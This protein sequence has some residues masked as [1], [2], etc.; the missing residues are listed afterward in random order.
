M[1]DTILKCSVCPAGCTLIDHQADTVIT[2][3]TVI[4]QHPCHRFP[5]LMTAWV[6]QKEQ[7]TIADVR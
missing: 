2:T 1:I 6:E 3:K 5:S 4:H 7:Q